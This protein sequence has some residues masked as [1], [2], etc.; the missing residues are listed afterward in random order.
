MKIAVLGPE[1]SHSHLLSMKIFSES[2]LLLCDKIE[3]VFRAVAEKR[4]EK[5]VVP[6]ENMLQGSVRE[7]ILGLLKYKVKIN[8]A[9]ILPVHHCLAGKNERYSKIISHP[10]ALGQC[11]SFL[12]GKEMVETSST[13]KAMEIAAQDGSYAAVG[14]REAAAHHGLEVLQ[15]SIENNYDNVTQFLVISAEENSIAG[16]ARTSLLLIPREDRPGLL[17]LLLA[18]FASQNI[19]LVKIES[20]PSGKKMGEYVFYL[21]IDANV[22]EEKV[23]SAL[24]FL[25]KSVEVYS[26]GSY[27]VKEIK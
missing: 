12:S 2:K 1:Y 4:A 16:E 8:E 18:P 3:D 9:Y 10:Q 13:S 23:K 15:E 14:S 20:L 26:L 21:E 19:N 22:R 27:Q 17:F 5:G 25:Q 24:D 6:I 11:S 7:S